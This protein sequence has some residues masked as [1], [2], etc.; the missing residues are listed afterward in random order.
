MKGIIELLTGR[1]VFP[2][3]TPYCPDGMRV[4]CVGDIH[5]RA[6]LLH[7][8]QEMILQDASEFLD[9]KIVIYLGD[10]ID[11]GEQSSEVID[12]LQ[13]KPLPGFESVYLRGNHEQT[14][15]DFLQQ[16]VVGCGWLTYGGLNTLVSYGIKIPKPPSAE[17]DYIA[18]QN[19]LLKQ[20]PEKHLSFLQDTR[21]SYSLGN[22]YFVHAGVKPGI[23][24]ES[25]QPVDQLWIREEFLACRK[26]HE[27]II[28]HGHSIT[29]TPEFLPNRI[30]I[31][32]GAYM[33]GRLS[34]LILENTLQRLIQTNPNAEDS[35][36][37]TVGTGAYI[38]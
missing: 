3:V 37:S 13:N 22:Y 18:L 24:L 20:L 19:Q 31:D 38:N 12:H 30:S 25:Q 33:S 16:P 15:L 2:T 9:R 32:T 7:Q 35:G 8:L 11:R 23:A 5:G 29:D 27:K 6:D 1:R 26:Y 14:M 28:V 21:L 17:Q 4:Y 10:Y 34:A 36:N